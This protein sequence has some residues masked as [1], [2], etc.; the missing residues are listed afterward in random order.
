MY[1]YF[2]FSPLQKPDSSE[3]FFHLLDPK[4]VSVGGDEGGRT[5]AETC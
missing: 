3:S 1:L 5:T 4:S 2:R